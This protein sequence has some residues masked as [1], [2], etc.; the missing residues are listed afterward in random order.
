MREGYEDLRRHF[1]DFCVSFDLQEYS[2][3]AALRVITNATGE[4]SLSSHRVMPHTR[5]RIKE[6]HLP[7]FR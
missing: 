4:A 6:G 2:R 5:L 1:A 7:Q 3:P